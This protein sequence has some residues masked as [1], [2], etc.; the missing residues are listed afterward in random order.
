MQDF[1]K[2][3][4]VSKTASQEEIKTAYRK[5]ASKN[6]PDKGG[7]TAIFQNIQAAYDTLGDPEKRSQYD[8]P[9]RQES[10]F[11]YQNEEINLEDLFRYFTGNQSSFEQIFRSQRI[12]NKDISI[13]TSITLEDAFAGKIITASVKLPSGKDEVI[14]F[15]IPPG[16]QNHTS[17]KLAGVGDD[18]IPNIPRGNLNLIVE[19]IKH[20]V[21]QQQG[22]DLIIDANISVWD[23]MLGNN[24]DIKTIEEKT[25]SIK[26]PAGIQH[27]QILSLVGYGMPDINRPSIRGRLLIKIKIEIP[28]FLSEEQ[29]I[30]IKQIVNT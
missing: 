19:I 28:K 7:D 1:Y 21:F 13:K 11:N 17:I 10:T 22:L 26:I 15:K 2:I 18:S 5:L 14:S 20:P 16:I 24:I 8:N 4:G 3:L 30:L 27:D 9:Y 12:K 23:A 25:L 29:K 6:H